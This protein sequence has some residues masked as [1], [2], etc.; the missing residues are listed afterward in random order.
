MNITDFL[1]ELSSFEVDVIDS[2]F[3]STPLDND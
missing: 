1:E 2:F 3:P